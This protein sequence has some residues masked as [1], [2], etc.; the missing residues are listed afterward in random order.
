MA[1]DISDTPEGMLLTRSTVDLIE[2]E[3]HYTQE[4]ARLRDEAREACRDG[5]LDDAFRLLPVV[6]ATEALIER[7]RAFLDQ[8]PREP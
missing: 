3:E 1:I 8:R 7:I 5:R 2:R 4:L 6:A